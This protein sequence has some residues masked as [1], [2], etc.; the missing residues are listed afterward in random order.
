[1]FRVAGADFA[2]V[3]AETPDDE[4]DRIWNDLDFGSLRGVASVG[5]ISYGWDHPIVSC[6][7]LARPTASLALHL[8]QIGRGSRPHPGKRDLLVLDHA[9]NTHRHGFYEDEREWSLDG[10]IITHK[11]ADDKPALSVTTCR[12][13]FGTFRT[14]PPKCPFC[15]W[16]IER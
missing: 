4:R 16:M 10:G 15:G 9:S 7:V 14:G 2:Y 8:Q 11:A 1:Q 13:C 5:V 3:D 6:V 12:K